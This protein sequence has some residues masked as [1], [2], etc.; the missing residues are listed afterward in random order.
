MHEQLKAIITRFTPTMLDVV[1]PAPAQAIG[2]LEARAGT[3]PPGYLEFLNWMGNRCPFLD[4][5]DL[6]YSP[7]DL[8]RVY[9]HPAR[10]VPKGFLLIGVDLSDATIDAHLRIEDGAI[11]LFSEYFDPLTTPDLP[12]ENLG[13][14]SFLLTA[15]VR[16]TLVQSHPLHFAAAFRG[17]DE[18]LQELVRRLD[19]ACAHFEIPHRIERPD[20]RFYGGGD[21]VIGLRRRPKSQVVILYFGALGRQRYEA[22]YDLIFAR[23]GFVSVPLL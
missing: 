14:E 1:A 18:Q 3:L 10:N 8:L 19:E 13:L 22:W 7:D 17:D 15:Y 4:G 5:E 12:L 6:A 9:A 21:F 11:A 16:K 20:F 23:W 2:R